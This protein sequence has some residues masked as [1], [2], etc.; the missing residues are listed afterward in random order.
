[1]LLRA[2]FG[3]MSE[4]LTASQRVFPRVAE[5][6]GYVFSHTQLAGA[7]EAVLAATAKVAV[8]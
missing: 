1:M 2:V 5:R 3:E 4:I 8:A 6:C 7:L